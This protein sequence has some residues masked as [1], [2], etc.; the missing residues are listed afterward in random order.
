MKIIEDVKSYA[1][2]GLREYLVYNNIK[3][4]CREDLVKAYMKMHDGGYFFKAVMQNSMNEVKEILKEFADAWE[5]DQDILE[6]DLVFFGARRVLEKM[7]NM[8]SKR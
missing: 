2:E 3:I 8:K 6:K 4:E 7:N 5:K 1:L